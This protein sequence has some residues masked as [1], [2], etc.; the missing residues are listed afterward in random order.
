MYVRSLLIVSFSAFKWRHA[1]SAYTLVTSYH[2][3][4][5]VLARADGLTNEFQIE[6]KVSHYTNY[7]F[8]TTP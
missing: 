5:K 6:L 2:K 8:T 1:S 7:I 4:N 3:F